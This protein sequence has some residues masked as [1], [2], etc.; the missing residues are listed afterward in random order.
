AVTGEPELKN[1]KALTDLRKRL[2]REPLAF[3]RGLRERL[4]AGHD[5]RTESLARLAE[6]SF[7]LGYLTDEIGDKQDALIAYAESLAIR[8]RLAGANPS[9][10]EFQTA[11]AKIHDNIGRVL[12]ET[13]KPADAL[14]SLETEMAILRKLADANPSVSAFQRDLARSH[15]HI[16]IL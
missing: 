9:V 5:T 13:G 1:N 7:D 16:G 15:N 14:K 8:E 11:V 10:S 12:K 6:A 4:Q 3:F 2:L